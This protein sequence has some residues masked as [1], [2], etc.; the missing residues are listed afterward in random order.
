LTRSARLAAEL[1][2]LEVRAELNRRV[3]ECERECFASGRLG[4]IPQAWVHAR[5]QVTR[6]QV[7]S[8]G[9]LSRGSSTREQENPEVREGSGIANQSGPIGFFLESTMSSSSYPSPIVRAR[10][11]HLKKA[12]EPS[13]RA[14]LI[15]NPV[16]R[17]NSLSAYSSLQSRLP[18]GLP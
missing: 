12:R 5:Q 15:A 11:Q 16:H 4:S 9:C 8:Q 6:E 14:L 18:Q 1:Q 10:P 13:H 7:K 2:N 3:R 17:G